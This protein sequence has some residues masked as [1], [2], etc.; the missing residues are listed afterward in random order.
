M[1]AIS[2]IHLSAI[3][4][5][6]LPVKDL[7]R[8]IVYYRDLLGMKFLFQVP[9]LAFFDCLGVRLMLDTNAK[10]EG[11]ENNSVIYYKVEDIQTAYKGLMESGANFETA[12]HLVAKMP[13]HELWM[14]FLRDPDNNLMALMAEIK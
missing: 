3:G 10:K 9:G 13:D 6:A 14:A 12:P 11:A 2:K 4:Q 7:D 1:S 5:I 8:A